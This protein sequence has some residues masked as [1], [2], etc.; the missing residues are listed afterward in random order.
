MSSHRLRRLQATAVVCDSGIKTTVKLVLIL[1]SALIAAQVAQVP[2]PPILSDAAKAEVLGQ[3]FNL[4]SAG[5][6]LQDLQ[7]R[8]KEI[9]AQ[10]PQARTEF[11][12]QQK[13][14]A[15]VLKKYERP[16]YTLNM[17]TL[18]YEPIKGPEKPLPQ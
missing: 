2:V 15:A 17:K 9:E 16:G 12:K 18:V 3:L 1:I 5:L 13:A 11:D 6:N 14:L 8:Q 7:L 4:A 10:I